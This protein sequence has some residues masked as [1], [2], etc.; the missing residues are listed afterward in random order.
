MGAAMAGRL[1]DAGHQLVVFN[2]TR[3][4]ALALERKGATVA[5]SAREVAQDADVLISMLADDQAV[6]DS[7]LGERG[8][9]AGLPRHHIHISSSTIGVLTSRRLAE[10]HRDAEQ[11]YVAA[12]VLGRPEAARA[13]KLVVLAAGSADALACCKPIFEILGEMTHVLGEV[14]ERANAAKPAANGL[15]ATLIQAIGEA[16]SPVESFGVSSTA[17]LELFN[18]S[19]LKSPVAVVHDRLAEALALGLEDKDWSAV[20]RVQPK[21]DRVARA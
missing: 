1:L 8:A 13:G 17:F 14:P 12:P 19:M 21:Q 5:S 7:F 9:L 10:L 6:L 15:L 18:G 20:A 4:K 16:Y 2:R 3:D 11:V